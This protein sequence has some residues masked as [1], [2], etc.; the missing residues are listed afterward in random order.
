MDG[1]P[2]IAGDEHIIVILKMDE[3]F[4]HDCTSGVF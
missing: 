4:E 3:T 2:C 1:F